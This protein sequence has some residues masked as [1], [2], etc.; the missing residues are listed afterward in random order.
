MPKTILLTGATD[1]IGL[2]T[3]KML[4]TAGHHVLLHGRNAEKLGN[5]EK[6]LSTLPG[7]GHVESYVADLSHMA[8]VEA[9]TVPDPERDLGTMLE[10]VRLV[11]EQLDEDKALIGFVGAPFTMACYLIEGRGS[12]HW[13]VTRRTMHGEPD[14]FDFQSR[15]PRDVLEFALGNELADAREDGVTAFQ[16]SFDLHGLE[17]AIEIRA[18]PVRRE[19]PQLS[20]QRFR[21]MHHTAEVGFP[22]RPLEGARM[23]DEPEALALADQHV[24]G[25]AVHVENEVV[26]EVLVPDLL[27]PARDVARPVAHHVLA[28]LSLLGLQLQLLDRLGDLF[29]AGFPLKGRFVGYKSGHHMNYRLIKEMMSDSEAWEIITGTEGQPAD[30]AGETVPALTNP[31]TA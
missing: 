29:L 14:L 31:V 20:E 16:E 12:K 23:I 11:R 4:V 9:L 3:A 17:V 7:G 26:E 5:V 28:L 25:V 22:T 2:E 27:D 18:Q 30:T 13:N 10:T 19:C 24:P 8:D 15:S 6:A 21:R 1:G